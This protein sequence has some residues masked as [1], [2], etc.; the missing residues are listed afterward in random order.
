MKRNR[1]IILLLLPLYLFAY[2]PAGELLK[3]PGLL[4][5]YN[6]HRTED[7]ELSLL[8]FLLLHYNSTHERTAHAEQ[9]SQLPFKNGECTLASLLVPALPLSDR[10]IPEPPVQTAAP[11]YGGYHASLFPSLYFDCIWQPPRSTSFFLSVVC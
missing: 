7:G 3:L 5:H 2:T 9:H 4:T 11:F 1:F 6:E 10:A 8:Q